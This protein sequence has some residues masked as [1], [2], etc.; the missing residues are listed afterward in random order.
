MHFTYFFFFLLFREI[1]NL[2]LF[3]LAMKVHHEIF[4]FA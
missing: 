4:W 2:I 1:I 3:Q